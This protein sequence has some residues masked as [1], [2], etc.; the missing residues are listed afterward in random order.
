MKTLK[1]LIIILVLLGLIGLGVTQGLIL[2]THRID[3]S[4]QAADYV[5]ILGAQLDGDKPKLALEYRLDTALAYLQK[6]P[7]TIAVCSGGQGGDELISE[8]SAMGQ[9]LEEK[10]I[11]KTRIL[12]EEESKNTF[13][14]FLYTT[15]LIRERS[16]T[17]KI[18]IST[19]GYHLY[20]ASM[21]AKRHGLDPVLLAAK[22]PGVILLK[23]Y[24]R[25]SL[26]LVKS[27]F[28]DR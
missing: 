12:L 18:A 20:R 27:Y 2:S 28:L 11:D 9:W 10:G 13:E 1:R 17:T 16:D 24:L 15:R 25:E 5:I 3:E 22:T 4:D 8:A 21:L 19:S 26:A 14:N 7:Q 23:S 6:H